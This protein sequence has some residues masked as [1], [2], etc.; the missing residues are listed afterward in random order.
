MYAISRCL[1]PAVALRGLRHG[2]GRSDGARSADRLHDRRRGSGD[3]AGRSRHQGVAGRRARAHRRHPPPAGRAATCA[4]AWPMHPGPPARGCRAGRIP[5]APS[6]ASSRSLRDERL[7]TRAGSTCASRPITARATASWHARSPS[8][9]TGWRP[10]TVV[11]LGCGTGS[12]LRAT[13][14]CSGAEQHWTLVDY[15]QALLEA[16]ARAARRLGRRRRTGRAARSRSSKAPSASP[17]SSAAPISRA[18]SKVR[19]GRTPISSRHR[20]LFDLAS[21]EFIAGSPPRSLPE[22]AAFYTVLTYNGDQRWTPEHE[23]DAALVGGLQRSPAARQGFRPGSGAG[24][25]GRAE[26][27]LCRRGLCS[28]GGRQRLAAG[29]GRRGTDRRACSWVCQC[30]AGDRPSRR[31]NHIGLARQSPHRCRGRPLRHAGAQP[32][33]LKSRDAT[34]QPLAAEASSRSSSV[35]TIP[36][37]ARG[38]AAASSASSC[39]SWSTLSC[40]SAMADSALTLTS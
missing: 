4:G 12:N 3:G 31:A 1:R 11:D 19:S 6:P 2:A 34:S 17:S 18:T 24:C 29:C 21:A 5:R 25:A 23:A 39:V 33:R 35:A 30:R 38:P 36:R 22:S 27:G 13:G 10:V 40:S 7:R 14:R 16:A 37:R 26:R 15:D 20:R 9:S 32:Q 8:T 28:A